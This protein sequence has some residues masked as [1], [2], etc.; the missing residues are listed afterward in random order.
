[1]SIPSPHF[2]RIGP[3]ARRD[4]RRGPTRRDETRRDERTQSNCS[5]SA[6]TLSSR[7]DRRVRPSTHHGSALLP[8]HRHQQ[9]THILI[10]LTTSLPSLGPPQLPPKRMSDPSLP[11]R[12]MEHVDHVARESEDVDPVS[13]HLSPAKLALVAQMTRTRLPVKSR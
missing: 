8:G 11:A 13:M 4:D 5:P 10:R 3:A 6:D 12:A 7:R 2:R 1:M 9:P